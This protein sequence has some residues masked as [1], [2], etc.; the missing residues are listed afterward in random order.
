MSSDIELNETDDL[1]ISELTEGRNLP[2]NLS[3]EIG[4]SRQYVQDRLKRLRETGVVSN[5]GNG[6]YELN[7]DWRARFF[8]LRAPPADLPLCSSVYL[9]GEAGDNGGN[10]IVGHP[11]Q[12]FGEWCDTHGVE[13]GGGI[14]EEGYAAGTARTPGEKE[15]V[16]VVETVVF[17]VFDGVSDIPYRSVPKWMREEG[18]PPEEAAQILRDHEEMAIVALPIS[19]IGPP[20][21][22]P[23]P[24]V[25]E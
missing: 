17:W 14:S 6:L 5:L 2:S 12:T 20:T 16:P 25:W 8:S 4:R 10:I 9:L 21:S 3:E 13:P 24:S 19:D 18:H 22:V 15:H 11:S 7:D 1:I 23:D